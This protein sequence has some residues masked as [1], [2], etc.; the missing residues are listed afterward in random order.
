G[1]W[2]LSLVLHG[3]GPVKKNKT[4]ELWEF[5]RVGQLR[6]NPESGANAVM[7]NLLECRA[8]ISTWFHI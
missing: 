8:T 3:Y 7:L 2:W 5:A 4:D 1:L 6:N